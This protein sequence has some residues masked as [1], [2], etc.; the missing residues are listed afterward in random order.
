VL[1]STVGGID[2]SLAGDS[3]WL[4]SETRL[5]VNSWSLVLKMDN[6]SYALWVGDP[7]REVTSFLAD[8]E[9]GHRGA[10]GALERVEMS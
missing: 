7:L 6:W 10:Q 5:P 2:Q 8:T 3:N 4:E 1:C 9:V